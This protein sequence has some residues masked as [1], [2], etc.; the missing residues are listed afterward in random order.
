MR[1]V[2]CAV[3]MTGLLIAA[4]SRARVWAATGPAAAPTGGADPALALKINDAL[5]EDHYLD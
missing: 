5:R 1:G 2:V 4:G 3:M